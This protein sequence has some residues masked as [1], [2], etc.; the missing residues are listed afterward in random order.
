[1]ANQ[2]IPERDGACIVLPVTNEQFM[3]GIQNICTDSTLSG[4]LLMKIPKH[5]NLQEFS[6]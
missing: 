6:Q 3:F 1:M 2:K 4:S 5:K